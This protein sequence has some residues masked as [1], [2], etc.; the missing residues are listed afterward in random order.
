[1]GSDRRTLGRG[2]VSAV[3]LLTAALFAVPAAQAT[4]L[5]ASV[6]GGDTIYGSQYRCTATLNVT[7]GGSYFIITLGS[8]TNVESGWFTSDG[9]YIGP[10][11]GSSFPAGD[12]GIIRY[13]G[14]VSHPGAIGSQDITSAGDAGVGEHVCARNEA[15][16]VV[17]GQVQVTGDPGPEPYAN[18][19]S[20]S[21]LTGAPVY[22]GTKVLG[23]VTDSVAGG[24]G[25][26][27]E[28]IV[29]I[30]TTWGVSVY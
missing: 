13:A 20:A 3:G 14:G 29:P 16:G 4:P 5:A 2:L 8:C 22:D 30:L 21:D 9:S 6:T 10:T 15:A 26:H 28:P 17:C 1:M 25:A 7:S 11:V 18:L 23:I 27:F 24:C 19:C 12:S